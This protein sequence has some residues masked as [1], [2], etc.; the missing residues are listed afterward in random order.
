MRRRR[1]GQ[2]G[3]ALV[4]FALTIPILLILVLGVVE[5]ARAWSA[6]QVITDAAREAARTAVVDN[7][8]VTLDSVQGVVRDALTRARLTQEPTIVVQGFRT[9]RGTNATVEIEYPYRFTW[10]SVLVGWSEELSNLTLK[11]RFVM[12]NE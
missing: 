3:Q 10:L 11:T 2:E 4:E 12:R 5:F 7:P 6:Y 1:K 8:S 9:G